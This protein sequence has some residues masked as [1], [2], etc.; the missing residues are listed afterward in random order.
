M[1]R[2]WLGVAVA[3]AVG[4]VF[5]SLVVFVWTIDETHFDRPDESF[6]RLAARIE[7]THGVTVDDSQRWVEAPTFSDPRSWIQLTVDEPDLPELLSTAC[8]ADYPDP[9]DWSLRVATDNGSVVSLAAAPAGDVPCLD[10]G[11]DAPGLVAEIGRSVP[12]VELQASIWD[13]GR[14]ALVVVDDDAGA[15]PALLP[16]VDHAED[17]RDAAGLDTSEPVEINAAALS[18]VIAADEHDRYLALL[19][20]L[21]ENHGVTSF[22]ADVGTQT[23]GIGKVQIRASSRERDGIENAI[24]TSGLPIADLPVRFLPQTP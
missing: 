16:L 23:D 3:A 14:F 17:V 10:F 8:A 6:D 24:R 5:A 12:N 15:L 20:D 22:S 2:V 11:F 1:K 18:V 19:T 7:K 13:N 21:A 9:V 4:A